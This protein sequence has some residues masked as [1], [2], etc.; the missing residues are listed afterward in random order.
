MKRALATAMIAAAAALG[1]ATASATAPP[2]SEPAEG[3]ERWLWANFDSI[4][5]GPFFSD[6]CV[7]TNDVATCTISTMMSGDLI[8]ASPAPYTEWNIVNID[9]A[10]IPQPMTYWVGPTPEQ[11]SSF[12]ERVRT[13][14]PDYIESA[15]I[16]ESIVGTE[17][18]R[19]YL[20]QDAADVCR[21]AE[22]GIEILGEPMPGEYF[23]SHTWS[24]SDPTSSYG[25]LADLAV[26][27]FCPDVPAYALVTAG[28]PIPTLPPSY[29]GGV[30]TVSTDGGD[31]SIPPG[32]YESFDVE[33]CYW[34]R[35]DASGETIDN[36]FG[37]APRVEVTILATDY[38][39]DS[40]GCGRW[41][42][43]SPTD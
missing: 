42:P 13:E 17:H 28:G 18:F 39:F 33:D 25:R 37:S 1:A 35:L 8:A 38:G 40:D 12:L 15:G 14:L 29:G 26:T 32:T 16:T 23:L 4:W 3:F 30:Y 10:P 20:M 5:S 24:M 19:G 36:Y 9:T 2:P 22:F 27:T 43:V 7:V 41:K 31:G 21:G 34:A 11:I 6:P